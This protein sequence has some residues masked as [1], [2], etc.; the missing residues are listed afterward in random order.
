M[1][2]D[3]VDL[4]RELGFS[5]DMG[6]EQTWLLTAPDGHRYLRHVDAPSGR[7][8]AHL[9]PVT[10]EE[11]GRSRRVMVGTSITEGM[12]DRARRGEFDVL[13]E[14]PLQLTID[15]RVYAADL[16]SST[17][18]SR[19]AAPHRRGR[20]PWT[21]W[22]LM[23]CLILADHPLRQSD[24][25]EVLGVS[26]QAISHTARQLPETV[27]VGGSGTEAIDSHLL[28]EQFITEYPGPGG[29]EFGWYSLDPPAAQLDQAADV[30]AHYGTSPLISGDIAADRIAPWRL[31]TSG[32]IY[33]SD[34]VDLAGDGFTPAPLTEATL[35]LC[36]PEDRTLWRTADEAGAAFE[37]SPGGQL[38]DP[39]IACWDL[40]RSSDVDSIAAA[41]KLA[42]HILGGPE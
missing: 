40:L 4:L 34:P 26:Q 5:I 18:R 28:L 38:A 11:A 13:T 7:I 32:R 17:P 36:V 12:L 33:V 27:A 21:R 6:R 37:E 41:E 16:P 25:A 9:H 8:T 14:S 29:H 1:T 24:I 19:S 42:A 23:R 3:I 10:A 2:L 20:R 15:R 39:V 35:V 31:P 22:A 30:A